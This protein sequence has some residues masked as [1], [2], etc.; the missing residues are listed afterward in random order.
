MFLFVRK[1]KMRPFSVMAMTVVVVNVRESSM[2]CH[3]VVGTSDT[4]AVDICHL[5]QHD[6]Y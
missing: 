2:L 6:H 4:T 3:F 1:I 5:K